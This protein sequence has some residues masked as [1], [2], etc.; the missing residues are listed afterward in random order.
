MR[1]FS[2]SLSSCPH[3]K[4]NFPRGLRCYICGGLE[5]ESNLQHSLFSR[6]NR[7]DQY[8]HEVCA[9]AIEKEVA[10]KSANFRCPTCGTV[11]VFRGTSEELG[12]YSVCSKCGERLAA[13]GSCNV[14]FGLLLKSHSVKIRTFG[15]PWYVHR[16]C[17][18]NRPVKSPKSCFLATASCGP[19]SLEVTT[20]RTFR[21]EKLSVSNLGHL[22][23]QAYEFISPPLAKAIERNRYK[24]LRRV[25]RVVVIMPTYLAVKYWM[26]IR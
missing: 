23:V 19:N 18:R 17:Q 3:C 22:F 4:S 7:E 24:F 10:A 13:I 25:V 11:K 21:D 16:Y 14:C 5:K 9:S 1:A 20:L 2:S 12:D 6:V 15:E 26:K 8:I